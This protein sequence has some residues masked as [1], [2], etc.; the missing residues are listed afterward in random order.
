MTAPSRQK[1]F[2]NASPASLLDALPNMSKEGKDHIKA[3]IAYQGSPSWDGIKAVPPGSFLEDVVELFRRHTDIPLELPLM[4]TVSH[5][6]GY[7]NAKGARYDLGGRLMAPLLWTVVLAPSGSGKSFA[8]ST[9]GRWL[10]DHNNATVVPLLQNASSAAKFVANIENTP[11]GLWLRDEF[12]QFL[13]QVQNL[14]HMEEMKD[15]LLRAY[16][17]DAIERRTK[18]VE[19]EIK[20]HALS[21]LGITV[22]DTFEHQIGAESLVD[23]FA[24]RFNY[25]RA[26]ADPERSMADFPI[27]FEDQN[28]PSFQI[29]FQRMRKSWL[30]LISRNDLP[31]AIFEF[32]PEALQLFKDS[33][34]ALFHE[35]AV[36]GS[37]FRRAMFS[38]FS[39]AVLFHVI[40]GKMGTRVGHDSLSLAVRMVALHLDHA[41]KLLDGYG[42]SQL[43]KTIRKAEAIRDKRMAQRAPLKPRDPDLGYSRDQNY[44]SSSIHPWID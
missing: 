2:Q 6:S 24:Q 27:Y 9:V 32:E 13:S 16:S 5:V 35:A 7:L 31:E 8:S 44:C 40:A 3:M 17:G 38:A 19:I 22:E 11:K 18:A 25:L 4:A 41:R 39:Y 10:T 1:T 26:E 42:L 36:P 34:R 28:C 37:F 33:F 30:N 23:G 12:G 29:P 43:E 20:D 14:Q 15:I 21:I